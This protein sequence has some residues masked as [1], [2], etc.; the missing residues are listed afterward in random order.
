[1][2]IPPRLCLGQPPHHPLLYFCVLFVLLETAQTQHH[3]K[4]LSCGLCSKSLGLVA[5]LRL[6]DMQEGC[7]HL[8]HW[9]LAFL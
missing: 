9:H 4:M 3:V 1:M 6:Q 7:E 5:P 2:S 8:E